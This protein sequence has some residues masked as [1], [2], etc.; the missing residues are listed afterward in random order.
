[1]KR[2]CHLIFYLLILFT[3][4]SCQP[5]ND[6]QGSDIEASFEV[7]DRFNLGGAPVHL[8]VK[9]S[10]KTIEL[11][12][13]LKVV[14][15]VEFP[16]DTQIIPPF[17]PDS[18]YHPLMLVE[19]PHQTTQ[20]SNKR[21]FLISRWTYKFEPLKSG[22]F[23]IKPF[24]L[25]FRLKKEKTDDPDKWPVYQINTEPI[26]YQVSSMEISET[27]DIRDIKELIL[28]AYQYIPVLLTIGILLLI[29]V[30]YLLIIWYKESRDPESKKNKPKTDYYTLTLQKL[31]KLESQNLISKN[32]FNQLHTQLSTILR[33]FIENYFGLRAQEQTTEEFMKEMQQSTHFNSEQRGI[34]ANFLKLADLVKFATYEPGSQIS[35]DAMLIIRDF[36]VT[37]RRKN[38]I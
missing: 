18:V 1:M 8:N 9:F 22:D 38:E 31:D 21:D 36:V 29:I 20:W 14:V 5:S 13:F 35:H 37:T 24:S 30:G 26:L 2:C 6:S 17:L 32:E 15:E 7:S 33:F 28:P 34:L 16:E 12:D 19:D 27:D 25:F 23:T 11:T 3:L 10:K 4:L